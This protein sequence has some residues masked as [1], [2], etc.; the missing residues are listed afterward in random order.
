MTRSAAHHNL[1]Q[2]EDDGALL[3]HVAPFLSQGVAEHEAVVLVVDPR[4][5]ALLKEALSGVAS[6]IDYI[7]RD[8]YYTRPEDALAGYDAQIR[9]YLCGGAD[10][11]RVFAE[12]PRCRTPEDSDTWIQY[13]ALVNPALAHHPVTIVCGLDVREQ[14]DSVQEGSW[15]THPRTMND[16]WSDNGHYHPPEEI[17]RALAR[18][19][20]DAPGLSPVPADT[21][22]G[23]LR[24]LLSDR[25]SAADI[26]PRHAED[27]T[28][29]VVE[30]LSNAHRYG[31]GVRALRI[32]RVGDRFV[33]EIS[34][35]GPGLEDPL[36]GYMPPGSRHARGVGLWVARQATRRLDMVSTDRGLTTRLWV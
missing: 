17:A 21:E 31:G 13:E 30:V 33:C 2:Y 11:V 7:D 27:M 18:A 1:Y 3:D 8:T 29:A 22:P 34:D 10:R 20:E 14:P 36:A 26:A 6:Q 4:K 16:A 15:H 24:R 5:R 25:M 28:L 32:G 19:P 35:H 23:A 12:L 9:R